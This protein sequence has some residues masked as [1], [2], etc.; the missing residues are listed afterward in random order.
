MTTA[1]LL[2]DWFFQEMVAIIRLTNERLP[3][4]NIVII[5]PEGL[6]WPRPRSRQ[7]DFAV[8]H[9]ETFLEV[10]RFE[11][12]L[13]LWVFRITNQKP[14]LFQDF[15]DHMA[16]LPFV[17]V[18]PL[19][20]GARNDRRGLEEH[21]RDW[22]LSAAWYPKELPWFLMGRSGNNDETADSEK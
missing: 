1:N 22:I 6:D 3:Q 19:Y 10:R 2:L 15:L 21:V 4:A 16:L 11:K 5:R 9:V 17:S 12:T 7:L 13:A 20:P 18:T 14:F 8:E